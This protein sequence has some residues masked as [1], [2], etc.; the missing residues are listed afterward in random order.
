MGVFWCLLAHAFCPLPGALAV[1]TVQKVLDGDTVRLV[2]GR[3]VRLMGINTPELHGVAT[4]E[5][6]AHLAQ[7][8]LQ[9]LVDANRGR[10]AFDVQGTDRYQRLL[11]H[12]YGALGNNIEAALLA[13]GLGYWIA[14][15]PVTELAACQQAAEQAAQQAK[16]GVWQVSPWRTPKQ[17][18]RAGFA[19]LE[20]RV[21]EVVE[22]S[23]GIWL[24]LG[25][26]V[27]VQIAPKS[28]SYF[29]EQLRAGMVGRTVR[30]RG[31]VVDR[32]RAHKKSKYARWLLR[33]GA[34]EMLEVVSQ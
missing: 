9:A 13:Q 21:Q 5:P 7:E 31:W 22:N 8:R 26:S 33:L 12:A 2:D 25:D 18:Q 4:P 20:A 6:W 27:V 10:L 14:V 28:K 30:V 11:A 15:S 3:S 17:I 19:L 29:A 24:A 23:G 1:L 34:P 16:L 32:A